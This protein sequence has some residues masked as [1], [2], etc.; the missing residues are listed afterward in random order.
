MLF[1]KS[2][3]NVY[4]IQEFVFDIL[5]LL[6]TKNGSTKYHKLIKYFSQNIGGAGGGIPVQIKGILAVLIFAVI[7]FRS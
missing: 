7:K 2:I 4:V 5:M 3:E 6:I 1:I